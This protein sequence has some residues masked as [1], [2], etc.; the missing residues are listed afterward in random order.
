MPEGFDYDITT[1]RHKLAK[2]IE[3]SLGT[4]IKLSPCYYWSPSFYLCKHTDEDNV[5]LR[6]SLQRRMVPITTKGKEKVTEETLERMPFTR[7]ISQK[8]MGDAI[9]LSET[10]TAENQRRRSGDM[11]FELPTDDVVDVSIKVF[12]NESV[13]EDTPLD[14][15]KKGKGKQVKKTGKGKSRTSIVKKADTTKGKGNDSQKKRE[16]SKRKTETSYVLKQNSKQGPGMDSLADL[17]EIQSWTHL[18][19]TK[20][21]VLHEKKV[22]EFNYNVEFTDDGSLNTWVGNE[23]LHLDE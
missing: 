3:G 2:W 13:D 23:S 11:V 10:T 20:S 19:M 15:A 5:S 18:F 14:A 16:P 22:R 21:P 9:K 6:W 12:K 1:G 4:T 8:L 17:V 7:A